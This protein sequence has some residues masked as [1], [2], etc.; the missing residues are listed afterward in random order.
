MRAATKENIP[1]G[2]LFSNGGGNASATINDGST[3]HA[4]GNNGQSDKTKG[5]R[6]SDHSEMRSVGVGVLGKTSGLLVHTCD[7]M[8]PFY[9]FFFEDHFQWRDL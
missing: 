4:N 5:G 9:T 3:R 7:F 2:R 6:D 8:H 1:F